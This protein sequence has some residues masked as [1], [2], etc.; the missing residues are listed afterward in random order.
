[1][2]LLDVNAEHFESFVGLSR[3]EDQELGP[4]IRF[5]CDV[6]LQFHSDRYLVHLH[7]HVEMG[8]PRKSMRR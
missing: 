2:G 3:L 5:L 4:F 7:E 1:M 8:P 6:C